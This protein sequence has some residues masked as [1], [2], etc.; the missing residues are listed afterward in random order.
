[1][2]LSEFIP[3]WIRDYI[4]HIRSV[5][6]IEHTVMISKSA[7]IYPTVEIGA[8][9]YIN[10]NSVVFTGSIGSFCSIGYNVQIGPPEHPIHM[11]SSHPLFYR[12]DHLWNEVSKSV[13][14]GHDVWVGSNAVI[15]QGCT[16]GSGAVVAAGA[17]VTKD[18]P[19]YAIVG[20]V[21]AR[22]IKYRFSPEKI[23]FLLQNRWWTIDPNILMEDDRMCSIENLMK[24][25][26]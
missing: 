17:V 12:R 10:G 1:M 14:I 22:I 6:R 5:K 16:I 2:K 24:Y 7:K 26:E 8:Y 23:E 25:I 4:N 9:S 13:Q 20:G 18:V 15:L 21:P 11:V 19:P 3:G